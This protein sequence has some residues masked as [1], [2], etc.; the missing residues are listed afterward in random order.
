MRENTNPLDAFAETLVKELRV[1]NEAWDRAGAP[2]ARVWHATRSDL[3]V[4]LEQREAAL[5][6][7]WVE[8]NKE[9][10]EAQAVF[11]R[12]VEQAHKKYVEAG[13]SLVL[14]SPEVFAVVCRL[15]DD[16]VIR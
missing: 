6:A 12:R 11:L 13:G 8:S 14:W 5:K 4:T 15:M 10:D 1:R 3:K 16:G 7:H 9:M 2:Q